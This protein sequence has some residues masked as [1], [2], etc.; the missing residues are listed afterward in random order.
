VEPLSTPLIAFVYEKGMWLL[1]NKN[2][3]ARAGAE[4]TGKRSRKIHRRKAEGK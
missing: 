4:R 1:I 2:L 3:M